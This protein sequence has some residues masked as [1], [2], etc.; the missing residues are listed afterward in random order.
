METDGRLVPI[1]VTKVGAGEP[2]G[3]RF[4]QQDLGVNSGMNGNSNLGEIILYSSCQFLELVVSYQED[5]PWPARQLCAHV[6][7]TGKRIRD[8]PHRTFLRN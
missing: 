4:N 6:F 2:E 7:Q 3:L 1:V 5:I 8:Y